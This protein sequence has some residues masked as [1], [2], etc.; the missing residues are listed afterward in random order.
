LR[1]LWHGQSLHATGGFEKKFLAAEKGREIEKS[2]AMQA[3]FF[4]HYLQPMHNSRRNL[5]LK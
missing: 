1:K 2:L 3:R 4:I 5:Q